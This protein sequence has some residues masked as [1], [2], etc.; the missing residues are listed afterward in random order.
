MFGRKH[1]LVRCTAELETLLGQLL[2]GVDSLIDKFD[3]DVATQCRRFLGDLT[4]V[5]E[6][7]D[8]VA[9]PRDRRA[10]IE[11][12]ECFRR[13]FER[14]IEGSQADLV[15]FCNR[16]PAFIAAW[17]MPSHFAAFRKESGE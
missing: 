7:D 15:S 10:S 11:T 16:D 17:G 3:A 9:E 2:S 8:L 12:L 6:S 5:V 1:Y 13:L 14:L 4:S